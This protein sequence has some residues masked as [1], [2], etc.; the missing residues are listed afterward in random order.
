MPDAPSA[1]HLLAENQGF[2]LIRHEEGI[3]F[4]NKRTRGVATAAFVAF[5]L[6]GISGAVALTFFAT[7]LTGSTGQR[8]QLLAAAPIA[9]IALV[10]AWVG[11]FAYRRYRARQDGPGEQLIAR[12]N[13]LYAADGQQLAALTDVSCET[14]VD[15]TD[16][17]GGFRFARILSLRWPGGSRP[18]YKSYDQSELAR[19]RSELASLGIRQAR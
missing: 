3:R 19:L 7:A 14:S 6:S 13:A 17:M 15:W 8:E 18:I 5:G 12:G 9:L 11:R 16:G 4:I 1:E 10:A 2:Q